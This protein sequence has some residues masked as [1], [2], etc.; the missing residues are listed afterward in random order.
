MLALL[1]ASVCSAELTS[2]DNKPDPWPGVYRVYEG[3]HRDGKFVAVAGARFGGKVTITRAGAGY[4][5]ELGPKVQFRKADNRLEPVDGAG[6]FK[7]IEMVEK[8][9]DGFPV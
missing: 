9:A 8:D 6:S 2:K 7:W 5:V 4:D 1:L 3:S